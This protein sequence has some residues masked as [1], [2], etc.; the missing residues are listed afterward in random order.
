MEDEKNKL[1]DGGKNPMVCKGT[2]CL[3]E[4]QQKMDNRY[5]CITK[6][7][8]IMFTCFKG[9]ER[10]TLGTNSRSVEWA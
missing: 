4:S 8:E 3:Q 5:A 9:G 7:L 6:R 10:G 1:C 2:D